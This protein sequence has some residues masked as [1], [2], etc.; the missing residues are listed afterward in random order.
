MVVMKNIE[1]VDLLRKSK[2]E[3]KMTMNDIA[4][5]SNVAIR[6]VNR[7]F[8]GEDVRFS[9]MMAVFNALDLDFELHMKKAA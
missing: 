2:S 3:K 7:I 5:K 9:S 6:T 1:I 4:E 8:A